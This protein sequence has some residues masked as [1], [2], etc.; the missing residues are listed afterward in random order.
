MVF[1]SNALVT[2][3]A[4]SFAP[5]LTVYIFNLYG[6]QTLKSHT[7]GAPLPNVD[8]SQLHQVMFHTVC[9]TGIVVGICQT[10]AWSQYTIR[11]SHIRQPKH[12]ES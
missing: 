2:K 9:L 6:Y 10:L 11:N 3:P 7:A 12:L 5:M 4:L 1:G 8:I